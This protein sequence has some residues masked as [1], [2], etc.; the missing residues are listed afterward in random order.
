MGMGKNFY[1]YNVVT[2]LMGRMVYAKRP[3]R[4]NRLNG[5]IELRN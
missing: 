1:H 5:G 2:S 3:D 4:P